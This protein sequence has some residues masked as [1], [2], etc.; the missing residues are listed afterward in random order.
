MLLQ[1]L[2]PTLCRSAD[3]V[4]IL[5]INA[6]VV[7]I[8]AMMQTAMLIGYNDGVFMKMVLSSG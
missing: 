1:S 6:S 7:T 8:I 2:A 4:Y 3:L 5:M